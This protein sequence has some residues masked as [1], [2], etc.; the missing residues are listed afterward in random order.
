MLGPWFFPHEVDLSV[1]R[2]VWENKGVGDPHPAK[3]WVD[4]VESHGTAGDGCWASQAAGPHLGWWGR[5]LSSW[6]PHNVL[7]T[8]GELKG[9]GGELWQFTMMMRVW[10]A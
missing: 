3:A 8:T 7:G 1:G 10:V 6:T 5:S 4:C 2:C 9:I